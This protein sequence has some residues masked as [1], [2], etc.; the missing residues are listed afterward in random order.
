MPEDEIDGSDSNPP[1]DAS[2]GIEFATP[3]VDDASGYGLS[4]TL[5]GGALLALAYYG[6]LAVS[7]VGFGAVPEPFYRRS[8][9]SASGS[10]GN[11]RFP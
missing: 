2:D 10:S 6:Y 3:A 11:L 8:R 7:A 4:M 1:D 9:P 5:L